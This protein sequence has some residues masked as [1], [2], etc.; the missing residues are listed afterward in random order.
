MGIRD[1]LAKIADSAEIGQNAKIEPKPAQAATPV[2]V[3]TNGEI[4]S[5]SRQ[6][7]DIQKPSLVTTPVTGDSAGL[8]G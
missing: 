8:C 5:V 1:V 4:A 7:V 6:N 3:V 2:T